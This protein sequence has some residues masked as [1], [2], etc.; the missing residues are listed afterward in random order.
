MKFRILLYGVFSVLPMAAQ[1]T[2]CDLG[3][4]KAQD[5]LKAEIRGGALELK[6]QGER[7]DELRASSLCAPASR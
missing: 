4:Y 3:G 5:G 2:N 6:W 7:Q 1:G